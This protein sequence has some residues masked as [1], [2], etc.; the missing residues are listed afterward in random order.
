[1]EAETLFD[2]SKK[3]KINFMSLDGKSEWQL[4]PSCLLITVQANCDEYLQFKLKVNLGFQYK[5]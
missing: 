2:E 1:M 4:C 5:L 3:K